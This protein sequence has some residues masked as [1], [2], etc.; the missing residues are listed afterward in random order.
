MSEPFPGQI[1]LN[2]SG[3]WLIVFDIMVGVITT[4]PGPAV[5]D[6]DDDEEEED[7]PFTL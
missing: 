1:G 7:D 5:D 3:L 4:L 2:G 6:D